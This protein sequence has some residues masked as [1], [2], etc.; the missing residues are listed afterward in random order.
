VSAP[1]VFKKILIANRGEIASRVIKTARRMGIATV[2][3][4]SEADRDALHVEL[5]DEAVLVGPPASRE[6]YLSIDKIIAACKQT[7]AEAVHPGY[8]FLSE[9]A[10]FARRVEEEGIVFIGPK[11]ASIAAM[12]DKIA[13]KK[14]AVAAGVSTIPGHNAAIETADAA[15]DIARRIG[16]PVMIK[17]SAG[18]G[19]KGLRVAWNDTQ[20]HEG[21]ASCRNEARA[22]FGDDRV[23]V[24][25]FVEEPRHI[26]IQVL[27]DAHGHCVY[28]WERECSIQRRHQKVIEEAP[29]AF[30]DDATRKAMGEQAVALAKAVKY[31]SAG[32]V[33]FVVG[34]DRSFFFL[35]MNTRLQVEHPVTEAITGLD[36]VEQMIRVAAGEALAFTQEQIPRRGWAIECRIN[37]EDP[38]RG[39]LPST[40]RLVVFRPPAQTIFA[41][42][43]QRAAAG[44]R[45]DTGVYEGGE[46]PI[47]YDSMICKLIAVGTDRASAIA[48]MQDALGGFVVRG[49][50]SNILFQS[51]LLAHPRFAV[52]DF[53]TGF[54]AEAF[55]HGFDPATT[56][57][58][59]PDFLL[60]L[61][62]ATYRRRL[63]RSAGISGQL[64]GHELQIGERFVVLHV[65]AAGHRT[66]TPAQVR[67]EGREHVVTL[68]GRTR[69]FTFANPLR[70]IATHGLVDGQPFRAQVERLG[71]IYRVAHGGA[72]VELR[73]L[74]PRTAELHALMPF[75]PPPDLSR[76]LLSPMPGLLVD[77]AVAAGQAV[78]AGER[79]AIIEAMKMENIL[80]AA[81]NGVIARVVAARGASLAVDEVILEFESGAGAP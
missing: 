49:V 64:P 15:V 35:E 80:V 36:L 7:G 53:N 18:G 27:G 44:V 23:F 37:A 81:H 46:I 70:D 78:R 47:H 38:V 51:A 20:A 19:G 29:S 56:P 30:I 73:V 57:H 4:Y 3:V 74:S 41:G 59:D 77:V 32:T 5:A 21:F 72:Q 52:G 65:D 62:A 42:E 71:L 12:G 68:G 61:A 39:F 43:P 11:H 33:E 24:E 40:G 6:S 67:L 14:L 22:S 54:I 26:E 8:G 28:L 58:P 75:K 60:A 66:E 16:Y 17:A 45:V 76:F 48:T 9:N 13:S 10:A 69:R 1:A 31:Q 55:P 63:A 2:A 79:L 34:K 25:K 50:A